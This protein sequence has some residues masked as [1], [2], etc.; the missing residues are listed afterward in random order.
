M[1][2]FRDLELDFDIYDADQAE[3]Y[4]AALRNVQEK[5]ANKIPDEGLSDSI[6]RLCGIVFDFFDDVLGDGAHK[7]IFGDK[8]NLNTCM[9]AFQEFKEAVNG[10]KDAMMARIQQPSP[11]R[12]ARRA[13]SRI[14][15]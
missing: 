14:V 3:A 5:S 11:N 8:T 15:K 9:D 6:R 2:Q 10:Q 1:M 4:E 7:E 12:A 13:A